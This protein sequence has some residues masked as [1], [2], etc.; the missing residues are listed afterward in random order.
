MPASRRKPSPVI[1]IEGFTSVAVVG[2]LVMAS[3]VDV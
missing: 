1:Y 3:S 2:K